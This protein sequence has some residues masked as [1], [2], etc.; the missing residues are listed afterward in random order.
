MYLAVS[1]DLSC[2]RSGRAPRRSR[3]L[4][5]QRPATGAAENVGNYLMR[6]VTAGPAASG[7]RVAVILFGV[8]TILGEL[9]PAF[10]GI[11][12]RVVPGAGARPRRAHRVP[13]CAERGS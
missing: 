4:R 9:V 3:R 12:N 8:R 10:Q 7:S 1:L 6:G 2:P 13:V 5:R 11:A